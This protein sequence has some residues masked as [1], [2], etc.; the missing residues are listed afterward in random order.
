[1]LSDGPLIRLQTQ[2]R[3]ARSTE[4]YRIAGGRRRDRRLALDYV[5]SE[6][7]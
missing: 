7:Y 5:N 3:M 6:K 2:G 1:M 4:R